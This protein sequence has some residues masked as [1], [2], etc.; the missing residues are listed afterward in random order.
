MNKKLIYVYIV[1]ALINPVGIGVFMLTGWLCGDKPIIIIATSSL[2]SIIA[3]VLCLK[4][5][6]KKIVKVLYYLVPLFFIFV[7]P[8]IVSLLAGYATFEDSVLNKTWP[9]VW[10]NAFWI[11]QIVIATF[12]FKKKE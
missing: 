8:V 5:Y 12:T 1:F 3:A 2:L 4:E 6:S 9:F 11:A 10:M 7:F